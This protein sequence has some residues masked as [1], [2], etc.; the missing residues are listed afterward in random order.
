MQRGQF[1]V[2]STLLYGSE[3]KSPESDVSSCSGCEES[4]LAARNLDQ[5]TAHSGLGCV[6][7]LRRREPVTLMM[8]TLPPICHEETWESLHVLT[9]N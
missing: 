1:C 2:V 9:T 3:N 6:E 7:I 5:P 4:Q 8:M